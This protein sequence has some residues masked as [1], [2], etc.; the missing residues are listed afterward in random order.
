MQVAILHH[1][2]RMRKWRQKTGVAG[3]STLTLTLNSLRNPDSSILLIL[4]VC[5]IARGAVSLPSGT[6]LPAHLCLISYA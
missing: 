3:L 2:R 5:D 6:G 4:L 1:L